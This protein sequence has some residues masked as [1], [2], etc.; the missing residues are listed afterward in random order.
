MVFHIHIREPLANPIRS[1]LTK[2]M[3][4]SFIESFRE[5]PSDQ[6]IA[7]AKSCSLSLWKKSW[8]DLTPEDII[9]IEATVRRWVVN[10]PD[11][12]N[13]LDFMYYER[14]NKCTLG[15]LNG[16]EL[17]RLRDLEANGLYDSVK[18]T[19]NASLKAVV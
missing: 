4:K 10:R 3:S 1:N 17:R 19:C 9:A 12:E 15:L 6:L 11:V 18:P 7:N 13:M 5:R 16:D 8:R 14:I 2:I